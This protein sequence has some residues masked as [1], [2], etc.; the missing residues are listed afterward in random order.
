MQA[1]KNHSKQ[2]RLRGPRTT[3]A[4]AVRSSIKIMEK[5]QAKKVRPVKAREK[6]CK[7]A[8]KSYFKKPTTSDLDGFFKKACEDNKVLKIKVAGAHYLQRVKKGVKK[9]KNL[10]KLESIGGLLLEH[11]CKDNFDKFR[12]DRKRAVKRFKEDQKERTSR[13]VKSKNFKV[14]SKTKNRFKKQKTFGR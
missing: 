2:V 8:S 9:G 14:D 12:K 3:K 10:N 1:K 11:S 6:A 13:K 5:F 4:E 7:K